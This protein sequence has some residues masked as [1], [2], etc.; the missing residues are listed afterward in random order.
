MSIKRSGNMNSLCHYDSLEI[1]IF[2]LLA[3][4]RQIYYHNL[5][6]SEDY[7]LEGDSDQEK[8]KK[9]RHCELTLAEK[10]EIHSFVKNNPDVI[11]TQ[12][13]KIFSEKFQKH[14]NNK[15]VYRIKRKG[16]KFSKIAI[17][18]PY[19]LI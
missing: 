6:I 7:M 16:K 4:I 9:T 14:L 19:F 5:Q 11:G 15:I 13:A 3:Q 2:I 1:F 17:I 12:V 8:D 10:F 18:N